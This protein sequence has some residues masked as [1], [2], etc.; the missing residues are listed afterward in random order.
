MSE[1]R[2]ELGRMLAMRRSDKIL[3]ARQSFAPVTVAPRDL[4]VAQ[5]A[6]EAKKISWDAAFVVWRDYVPGRPKSTAIATQTPY[7]ELQ[8]LAGEHGIQC[9]E[10]VTPEL[11]RLFVDQMS[12]RG[13]AVVTLNEW[14]FRS[15]VTCHSGLS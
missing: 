12:V 7:L 15:I 10:S 2:T 5:A 4:V 1:Q 9:P 11:M 6:A 13:L 8:R 3:P 14:V